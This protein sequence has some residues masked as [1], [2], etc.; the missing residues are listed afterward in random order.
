[1]VWRVNQQEMDEG[2]C[3]GVPSGDGRLAIH[4]P[5]PRPPGKTDCGQTKT[6]APIIPHVPFNF[7]DVG[8]QD[9]TLSIMFS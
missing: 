4:P 6:P 3:G 7:S 9:L 1:C 8:L 5:A 2:P